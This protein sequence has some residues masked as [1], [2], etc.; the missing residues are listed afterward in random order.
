MYLFSLIKSGD[1]HLHK[2]ERI[3]PHDHY[4][5]LIEIEDL[6]KVAKEDAENYRNEVHQACEIIKKQAF[7]A[8][9]EQ[10]L[11]QFNEQIIFF[12][13]AVRELKV[14]TQQQLLPLVLKAAKKIVGEQIKLHPE[15]IISIIQQTIKPVVTH[16]QIRLYV[17]KS[18]K[19]TV[20]AEKN[21]IKKLFEKLE[22]FTIE[23]N[24]ELEPG[25]CI[26]ET[27]NGVINA[28][29]ENQWRAMESAF[30]SFSK[31]KTTPS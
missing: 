26:I 20:D 17:N 19:A 1:V 18:D 14:E 21:E 28:S 5:T 25:S 12:E 30:Q 13:D 9:Y 3:I 4:A 2:Q 22:I 24:N 8:G 23:E 27:E 16:H 10:G 6:M 29:L 7:D 11:K 15:T 31:K